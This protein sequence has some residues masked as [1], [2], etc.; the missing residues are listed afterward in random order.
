[1]TNTRTCL[2]LAPRGASCVAAACNPYLDSCSPATAT[3]T[4]IP[5]LGESCADHGSCAGDFYCDSTGS[6]M[7]LA[8]PGLGGDC[9]VSY[10]ASWPGCS[11]TAY[12]DYDP[13][14]RTGTCVSLIEA[15]GTCTDDG[16]CVAGY[17]CNEV[18]PSAGTC[19]VQKAA[20][21]SCADHWECQGGLE[22]LGGVCSIES[23]YQV[24]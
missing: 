1:V 6:G 5:T 12:C 8:L 4:A 21:S 20:G 3:C 9:S 18:R 19:V 23:C 10:Q 24:G 14:N 22:C 2:D 11:G 17:Y 16:T 15:G 13:F 7:C